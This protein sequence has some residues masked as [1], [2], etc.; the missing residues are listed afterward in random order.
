MER[1]DWRPP[2]GETKGLPDRVCPAKRPSGI[3]TP[4]EGCVLLVPNGWKP[5]FRRTR[6]SRLTVVEGTPEPISAFARIEELSVSGGK[7][8][9][10]GKTSDARAAD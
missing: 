6:K 4:C 7:G 5:F 9:E 8:R 10:G 3:H 1:K 2:R